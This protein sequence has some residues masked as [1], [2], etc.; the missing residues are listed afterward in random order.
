MLS[1]FA[2]FNKRQFTTLSEQEILALAISSEEDDSRIYRSFAQNLHEEYPDTARMFTEMADEENQHRKWL[3]DLH[4]EKFGDTIPLIRR[5][6]VKGF[7]NRKPEWLSKTLSV[8]KARNEA[9]DM[10]AQAYRFYLTAAKQCSDT[11]IRKL[12][13]DLA[14]AEAEHMVLA[15]DSKKRNLTKDVLESE[16]AKEKT[17]I[18]FNLC[19]TGPCRF[20]GWF[21]IHIGTNIRHRFCHP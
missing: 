11:S 16:D 4:Q 14:D 20:D 18:C 15:S 21:R 10:E 19:A 5:E 12:L 8:E 13:G 7:Y 6:H 3:I 17:R 2:N 1:R 9:T